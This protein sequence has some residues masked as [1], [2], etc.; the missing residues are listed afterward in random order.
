MSWRAAALGLVVL[1][2]GSCPSVAE[3]QPT[4]RGRLLADVLRE[5]Q[6]RGLDLVFSSAVVGEDLRVTVEPLATRPRAVLDE[7]LEPLGLEA[8]DGPAG[9]LLI[10]PLPRAPGD[11]EQVKPRVES[12]F[13]TE[14]VVTPG[15]LSLVRQ[16]Q[17]S[18]LTVEKEDVVLIPTFGGDIS[19][20]IERLPAVAAADNSAGF[21]VRGSLVEDASMILDGLELY[22]PFHLQRFQSPFSLVDSTLV[23]RVDLF[24]GGYTADLG[25]RHGGFLQISTLPP[26]DSNQGEVELG[27]LNSRVSYGAP[28]KDGKGSWLV[29]LRYWYPD[30]LWDT[31]ELGGGEKNEPRFGD[32][33]VKAAFN[34]SPRMIFSVHGLMAYD[35]LQFVETSVPV[36]ENE[37]ASAL[38]RGAYV[39][40][41][42]LNSWTKN[43][44]S[45]TVLS[46]GG[47]DRERSGIGRPLDE[48]FLVDDDRK[49]EFLGLEHDTSWQPS[50]AHLLKVGGYV[51]DLSAQYFYANQSLEDP[52]SGTEVRPEPEG[53]S[54]GVY[55]AWR[56]ALAS[57]FATEVG[58]RWDGQTYTSDSQLSPRV[59]A[60]WRPG[61][62]SE[63]RVGVGRFYQSQR[64]HELNVEDGQTLF[65][66]AESAKQVELTFQ[67]R[68]GAG[69]SLR[70]DAYYRRLTDVR[71]RWENLFK[72]IELFP[73]IGDDRVEIA[74]DSARLRGVELLVRGDPRRPLTWWVG[75]ALSSA[76]DRVAGADILRSWDQTHAG[77][78]LVGY[79]WGDRWSLSLSGSAHSGW[80]TTPVS[81]V[82]VTPPDEIES[83][84]GP[85]N[86]IR[87]SH[88]VRFDLKARRSFELSRGRLWLTAEIV[89]L[90]DRDNI[91]CVD[92]FEFAIEPGGGIDGTTTYD[93]W[94]GFTPAFSV[95]WEF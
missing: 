78:F 51:R 7:I 55:V 59:N 24:G 76:E 10:V 39:W 14:L 27:T 64:I 57:N 47:I 1:V 86:S 41:R 16:E 80:P 19:R 89:N 45:E 90:T 48:S 56:A 40:L 70:I 4:Y 35:R 9:A 61:E 65:L 60:V 42:S 43:V 26:G 84:P 6:D 44:S 58:L 11:E 82:I 85:R 34:L 8:K 93:Y 17:A 32:A 54:V 23:D 72:P 75:Y 20:V 18:S 22:D 83:V 88:Y 28:M 12:T 94:L 37:Q 79:R 95:L 74:P 31:I 92:E 53:T 25:D 81:G 38:N 33:Y 91:C 21:H 15:R 49:L 30:A 52:T 5:M 36:E 13:V 2:I 3:A 67:H 71:P 50:Q 87:F 66:P 62:R 29:S 77:E 46:G 68:F 63:L 73:E 69:P